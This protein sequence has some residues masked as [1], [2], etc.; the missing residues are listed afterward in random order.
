M[1][2]RFLFPNLFVNQ[3]TPSNTVPT[4]TKTATP[5]KQSSVNQANAWQ[6]LLGSTSAPSNWQVIPCATEATLLCVTSQGKDLGTVEVIIYALKDNPNFQKH[7]IEVGISGSSAADLQNPQFQNKLTNALQ[8]WVADSYSRFTKDHQTKY[9]N[10]SAF[11]TYP[12]QQVTV[13]KL[14]G[15]R[16]GFVRL[17]PDGGIQEQYIGYVTSD[18]TQLYVI[19][20]SFNSS[21]SKGKFDNLANLAIFQ[22]YLSAIAENL[23]LPTK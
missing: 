13:G 9:A 18:A 5:S 17:K 14:P 1:G 10:N 3:D 20:T 16:Y 15:M 6:K 2:A 12:L 19:T 4:P 22:P 7:L 11:S 21:L 8:A 23:N